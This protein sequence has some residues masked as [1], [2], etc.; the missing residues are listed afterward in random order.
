MYKNTHPRSWG[1]EIH[2]S[3]NFPS[4][5]VIL[6]EHSPSLDAFLR[7]QAS[8][9]TGEHK[10]VVLSSFREDLFTF[11]DYYLGPVQAAAVWLVELPIRAHRHQQSLGSALCPEAAGVLIPASIHTHGSW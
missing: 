9:P 6:P 7:S 1:P 8:P 11:T 10:A 4:A 3:T 2:G 5:F